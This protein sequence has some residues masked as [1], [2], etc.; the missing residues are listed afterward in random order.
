VSPGPARRSLVTRL[1][2]ATRLSSD[3]QRFA[4][5]LRLCHGQRRSGPRIL[6]CSSTY[7]VDG[8]ALFTGYLRDITGRRQTEEEQS[9]LFR[10]AEEAS[11][12]RERLLAIVAHDLRN[13]LGAV[14]AAAGLLFNRA[15][16]A[17]TS[18]RR[19]AEKILLA[20]ARMDRLIADL[21]DT[22]NIHRGQLSIERLPH[23]LGE[24][25]ADAREQHAATAAEKGIQ[26]TTDISNGDLEYVY[27]RDRILQVLSNLIG[28]AI[29]FGRSRR[30]DSRPVFHPG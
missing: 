26:L 22:A 18:I 8:P 23:R 21:L 16:V 24:V 13:P 19:P 5:I 1:D 4:V 12:M 20:S 9:R 17:Q 25:V 28:N 6:I 7:P 11:R 10:Q 29:T 3:H 15:D 14:M 27:D 30:R 2:G